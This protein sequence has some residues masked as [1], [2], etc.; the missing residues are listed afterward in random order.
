[1]TIWAHAYHNFQGAVVVIGYI[2][3]EKGCYIIRNYGA[4]YV[5]SPTDLHHAA[6]VTK[7]EL[8]RLYAE[9]DTF[10]NH[11]GRRITTGLERSA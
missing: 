8:E 6:K 9:T 7:K 10:I 3:V 4:N 1:M 2:Q 5:W 11:I